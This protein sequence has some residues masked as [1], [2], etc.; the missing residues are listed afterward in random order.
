MSNHGLTNQLLSIQQTLTGHNPVG[1][2]DDLFQELPAEIREDIVNSYQAAGTLLTL[3]SEH[4][5]QGIYGSLTHAAARAAQ[6]FHSCL[7]E[8]AVTAAEALKAL[9]AGSTAAVGQICEEAYSGSGITHTQGEAEAAVEIAEQTELY[10][11]SIT[12]PEVCQVLGIE[13]LYPMSPEGTPAPPDFGSDDQLTTAILQ[14]TTETTEMVLRDREASWHS[15]L[16]QCK[17]QDAQ[18]SR[19]IIRLWQWLE[20]EGTG[21]VEYAQHALEVMHSLK[22][23]VEE[24]SRAVRIRLAKLNRHG[25]ISFATK[26]D[27]AAIVTDSVEFIS[28]LWERGQA[29]VANQMSE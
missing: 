11:E 6:Y 17:Q 27:G 14:A 19:E 9:K 21:D 22:D 7:Q 4:S 16:Q 12:S 23:H 20:T 3:C 24:A 26:R 18:R 1:L 5:D 13:P 25:L 15:F 29:S 28:A 2:P 8:E 10:F